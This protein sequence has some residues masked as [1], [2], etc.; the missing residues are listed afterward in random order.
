[1][2]SNAKQS[3]E[4][5]GCEAGR[6]QVVVERRAGAAQVTVRDNGGGI[7]AEVLPR[8]F[9]PYFTTREGGTGIGLYMS[10]MIIE[11]NMDGSIEL[12]NA[13]DGAEAVIVT[14]VARE[15]TTTA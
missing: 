3:I 14:P 6:V 11:T 2:L 9:D 12:R 4:A 10:K 8:V 7:P 5:R 15:T 1:L 13:E